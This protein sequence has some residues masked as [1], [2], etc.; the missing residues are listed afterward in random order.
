MNTVLFACVHYAGRSQM[1]AAW[2]NLLSD[3]AKARAVS[4]G[5]DPAPRVHSEVV[6]AMSEVGVDLTG[7]PTS[8][9]TTTELAR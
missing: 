6:T 5:T 7:A 1:A 2:F 3:S 4:A 8:K 9:L